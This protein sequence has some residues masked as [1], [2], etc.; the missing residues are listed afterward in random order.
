MNTFDALAL[1]QNISAGKATGVVDFSP[2]ATYSQGVLF[3]RY[4][5]GAF[6]NGT[7]T[8]GGATPVPGV[9]VTVADELGVPHDEATT[10]AEGRY[11]VRAPF[12]KVGVTF[13]T[14]A[15]DPRTMVGATPLKTLSFVVTEDAAMR[16]DVDA[17]G[18]GVPDWK[19]TRD[20]T[21]P[22]ATL[23][24]RVYL[25]TNGNGQFD[26]GQD[27]PLAGATVRIQNQALSVANTTTADPA[28][29][30]ELRDVYQG[31]T[32]VNVTTSGRTVGLARLN[33]P[34]AGLAQDLAVPGLQ[35]AGSV[36]RT[37]GAAVPGAEVVAIDR[38]NGTTL[39]A[40]ADASGAYL[41][42]R[43]LAG[44]FELTATSGDLSSLPAILT[45]GATSATGFNLTAYPGGTLQ[46]TTF[47]GGNVQPFATVAFTNLE[48]RSLTRLVT[49]D[50]SGRYSA[51]L[52]VGRWSVTGRHYRGTD[53]FAAL[54]T[55]DVSR[56]S[57]IPFTAVFS[58]AA[59]VRG[60]AYSGNRA[61][62]SRGAAVTFR[63]DAGDVLLARTSNFG[64]YDIDA[65]GFDPVSRGP[66]SVS[67]LFA[68]RDIPLVARNV[69]VSGVLRW[70][71]APLTGATVAIV[72]LAVGSGGV[73]QDAVVTLQG[74][75]SASLAPG[76]YQAI[77]DDNV[78]A[79][80]DALRW[81][82][83]A[84]E[85]L[86]LDVGQDMLVHDMAV[87]QRARVTGSV[88]F[89]G[90]LVDVP[91][92]F[93]GPDDLVVDTTAGRFSTYVATGTYTV[94]ANRTQ[95][96]DT[97]IFSGTETITGPV[98]LSMPLVHATAVSGQVTVDGQVS[99][100][101]VTVVFTRDVG[102]VFRALSGPAGTYRV[103][104]PDGGFTVSVDERTT[105]TISGVLRFV[106]VSFS[107]SLSVPVGATGEAYD[108]AATRTLDN[109]TVSGRVTRSGAGVAATVTFLAHSTGA[110]NGTATAAADG[111][112][113]TAL[114]PGSY[115][116]HAV[117]VGGAWA[118]LG[119]LSVDQGVDA[120]FDV[121]LVPAFAVTGVTTYKA[122]ARVSADLVFS[123]AA[124]VHGKSDAATGAYAV[125][126]PAPPVAGHAG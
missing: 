42:R 88:T 46:G 111:A 57:T 109:S 32:Y 35:I 94:Y 101:P 66:S 5:D 81:Q 54:A 117:A 13:S 77:V 4:Y 65:R 98:D 20:I 83:A 74:G 16:R 118:F 106:R 102:G 30:Y 122:G 58:A 2:A 84:V 21:L 63:N 110:M 14:G 51:A 48:D 25:D 82:T 97:F 1:Q 123:A 69:T 67:S 6:V 53:L 19:I 36:R 64:A 11:A 8:V 93:E 92:T 62:V 75:Y 33:V 68:P 27:P 37:D 44:D 23:S 50:A 39:R 121:P 91:V 76:E 26:A 55:V 56:G 3:A 29:R 49:S 60:V 61:N 125:V 12:G 18:D 96:P 99:T 115:S 108:V 112:Y 116:V 10:D 78:S 103:A 34:A 31:S 38:T 40:T 28:G 86:T 9:H 22:A 87:V 124:D 85:R 43:L 73:T 52:P 17:D 24:G 100:E 104:V 89:F 114:Q 119:T 72:F 105:M 113:A 80:S 47:V 79:G 70:Q 45:L 15:V 7:V 126:L 95:G 41:V 120:A 71:G 107:G 59:E 90:S